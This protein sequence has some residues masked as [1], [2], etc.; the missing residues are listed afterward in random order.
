MNMKNCGRLN[1]RKHREIK[2]SERYIILDIS[3]KFGS[4]DNIKSNLQSQNIIWE[5]QKRG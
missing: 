4:L 5:Y 3:L 1:V 2:D